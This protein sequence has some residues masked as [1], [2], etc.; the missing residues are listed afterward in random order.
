MPGTTL[1]PIVLARE[2]LLPG[3]WPCARVKP[4]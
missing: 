2:R 3:Y 4:S 1:H